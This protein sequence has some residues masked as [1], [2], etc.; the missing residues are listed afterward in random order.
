MSS[1]A[2]P[3]DA[4]SRRAINGNLTAVLF[5]RGSDVLLGVMILALGAAL[6]ANLAGGFDVDSWLSLVAGRDVWQNGIPQHETLTVVAHGVRWIDQQWLSQLASYGIYRLGGLG[7]F[8][9]VSTALFV[10]SVGGATAGARRLGAPSRAVLMVLPLSLILIVPRHEV[11]TQEFAMPLFVILTYLLA[12]DSRTPSRRVYW[13]FPLLVLWANLHGTVTLG[14]GLVALRGVTV[15]WERRHLLGHSLRQWKR[16]VALILGAS[17]SILITPYGLGILDYY[18]TTIVSSTL[19]HAV[20]EWQPITTAPVTAA[21]FFVLA[22]IALWAFGRHGKRTTTWERLAILVLAAG[23]ISVIRNVLFFALLALMIVP[24]SLADHG[25]VAEQPADRTRGRINGL[26]AAGAVAAVVIAGA[27]ALMRPAAVIELHA[28]RTGVLDAVEQATQADPSL[29]VLADD[30]FADWLLWR[31]PA[32]S[33][34]LANDV[35]FELLT[36]NQIDELNAVFGV[37]GPNWKQAARG[38]RL[39]VLDKAYD[40]NA[41]Q[42]FLREPGRRVLYDDGER[43]VILRRG[44]H[45]GKAVTARASLRASHTD[46]VHT[47]EV[48][49]A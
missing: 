41:V 33:G 38:Y 7:L 23:S 3:S 47:R 6:L 14:A 31:D 39:L 44:R 40:P 17:A 9:L 4:A 43:L 13:C 45:A 8:G 12:R 5:R 15:A 37:I 10:A 29:R 22:G 11:R 2:F 20:S 18:R 30:H 16:P 42:A 36:A 28:Q 24:L 35:R 26:L 32:L 21:V 25:R 49:N 48:T 27:A 34:R 1:L 46:S 19:R